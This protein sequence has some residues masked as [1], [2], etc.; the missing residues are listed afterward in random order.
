MAYVSVANKGYELSAGTIYTGITDSDADWGSV[1]ND[2]YFFDKTLQQVVY[3][4]ANGYITLNYNES[5]TALQSYN[6]ASTQWNGTIVT[7]SPLPT[8]QVANGMTFF[9]ETEKSSAGTTPYYE[10]N[11]SYGRSVILSGTSGTA[12]INVNGT[13]YL[14][15]FATDLFTSADNWVT[16]NGATIEAIPLQVFAL[17]SGAD[18]RI[19]FGSES[20]TIL[21]NITITNVSGD[22][23]GVVQNEFT[24]NSTADYDHIVVP[25]LNTPVANTYMTHVMRVN[26]NLVSGSVQYSELGLYRWQNDSLI[27]SAYLIIRNPDTTGAIVIID[28]YTASATDSFVTGG[29]YFALINNTGQTLEFTGSRGIL[30]QTYFQTPLSFAT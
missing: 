26:F 11:L 3:K 17:G 28:T 30:I 1:P 21:N 20:N 13:N 5:L 24:G 8:G 16:T 6:L 7:P 15:T 27:G 2:S 23:S 12:N 14:I 19:R 25:Y 29:F 10:F 9:N 4:N 18:G 22:L